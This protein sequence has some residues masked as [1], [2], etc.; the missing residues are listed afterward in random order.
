MADALDAPGPPVHA[1]RARRRRPAHLRSSAASSTTAFTA[2]RPDA[3]AVE[4]LADPQVA[5]VSLTITEAGLRRRRR[6]DTTFDLLAAA[7]S[8]AATRARPRSRSSAATT[9]QATATRHG[10]H[11]RRGRA[12]GTQRSP[13]GSRRRARS[14]TRWSTGSPRSPPTTIGRGSRE[15]TGST[16]AGRSSPS[17]SASGSSRTPSPAGD[18]AWE[19]AGAAVHRRRPR[20]GAVQAADAQRRP[21][22]HGVPVR[23]GRAHVTSTRRWPLPEVRRLPRRP[24]PARGGPVA[25]PDPGPPAARTTSHGAATASPTPGCA[26]RSPGCA[27][28]APRSSRR[29]SCRPSTT[30][31]TTT[32]RCAQPRSRLPAGRATSASSPVRRAGAST[33]RGPASRATRPP[34]PL[35][36]PRPFLELDGVFTARCRDSARFRRRVRRRLVAHRGRRPAR[37]DG[38]SWRYARPATRRR[39]R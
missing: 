11:A 13:T 23:A 22:E 28:T 18:R 7:S 3:T 25:A 32:D 20:V 33:R 6:D 26:T 5:I 14:P 2:G 31:S 37:G 35:D 15:R 39:R 17:R 27:S 16:T 9:C 12:G 19:D 36:D 10:R 38:P 8:D 1:D 4:I 30:S 24:A 21:L 29:S 34:R